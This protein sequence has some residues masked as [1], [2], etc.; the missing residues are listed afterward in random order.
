MLL[1]M[2]SLHSSKTILLMLACQKVAIEDIKTQDH[3]SA[4]PD[5]PDQESVLRIEGFV[6]KLHRTV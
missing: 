6:L 2:L 5:D 4:S 1:A 3:G